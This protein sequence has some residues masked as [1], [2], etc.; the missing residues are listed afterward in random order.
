MN[1]RL[2]CLFLLIAAAAVAACSSNVNL[3]DE[4]KL[5]DR[6]LLSGEPC[7]APCWNGITPGETSYRD[8]KLIVESNGRLK[9]SEEPDAQEDNPGRMF[10]FGEGENQPCCQVVSRDGETISSFLLQLAPV[11]TFG[12]IFDEYG[13]PQ[14]VIGHAVSDEQA[15]LAM[16]YSDIQLV[17]YAYVDG[18]NT[19]ELSVGSPIIGAL[20]MAE[21][22]MQELLNCSS[23]NFWR[24]FQSFESYASGETFDFV[25]SDVG[26]E[27][28]CPTE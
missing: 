5:Q 14:F 4:S 28:A 18:G 17:V 27:V 13:E 26:D 10:T 20:Y 2:L 12:P 3:L 21:P 6:S 1:R 22:E 25:G 19:G 24:G 23:M 9:I 11:M 15:Y 7:V 16:I 8:A